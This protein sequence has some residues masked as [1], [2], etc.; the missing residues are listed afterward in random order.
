MGT[1]TTNHA[2]KWYGIA[3]A[4]TSRTCGFASAAS[5]AY[6]H[7]SQVITR[8][9]QRDTRNNITS[10]AQLHS[11]G[12]SGVYRPPSVLNRG[13]TTTNTGK[14]E[15]R[16]GIT[17]SKTCANNYKKRR[18][19]MPSSREHQKNPPTWKWTRAWGRNP[20]KHAN[21]KNQSATRSASPWQKSL[22][23]LGGSFSGPK[24]ASSQGL[25]AS[26]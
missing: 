18:Q 13:N 3:T 2:V 21:K 24:S 11:G 17:K 26:K 16:A 7:P 25:K 20:N 4:I 5:A 15:A 9:A 8:C 1:T 6:A 12:G 19:H 23:T 14:K 22:P 10:A